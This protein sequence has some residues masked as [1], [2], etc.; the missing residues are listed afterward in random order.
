MTEQLEV[1]QDRE[2]QSIAQ[3]ISDTLQEALNILVERRDTAYAAAI[4]P[5]DSEAELLAKESSAITEAA[6]NLEALLPAQA[7]EAQ[8]QADVLLL[9]G[10][11]EAAQV[12]MAEQREA[13]AAPA[14]M[15][16]RQREIS[17][18]LETIGEEKKG[19]ARRTFESWYGEAQSVV[20][21]AEGGLFCT[22]LDGL[23]KSFY[24]YQEST[25]TGA[26]LD[27]PYGFLVKDFILTNLTAPAN[28]KEW[29]SGNLWYGG[30]R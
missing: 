24:A 4:K 21:A 9:G 18:R 13:E 3:E 12:K 23:R 7:R 6:Q 28:S 25:D 10:K 8:R 5:L 30:R 1:L 19:I 26:T 27:Q 20:R 22:L 29:R 15:R 17:K 11:H 14:K 2:I 16:E